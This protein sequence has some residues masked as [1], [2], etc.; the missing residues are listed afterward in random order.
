M[1]TLLA[2]QHL[3]TQFIHVQYISRRLEGN[4]TIKTFKIP[5]NIRSAHCV[6]LSGWLVCW[7]CLSYAWLMSHVPFP[8]EIWTCKHLLDL[9]R[10]SPP[11]KIYKF[12]IFRDCTQQ[13]W[14]E[15]LVNNLVRGSLYQVV[16]WRSIWKSKFGTLLPKILIHVHLS[17]TNKDETTPWVQLLT[18]QDFTNFCLSVQKTYWHTNKVFSDA[19][20]LNI[21]HLKYLCTFY[22]DSQ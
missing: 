3:C 10:R 13:A 9:Q 5:M 17:R 2:D 11:E 18:E 20:V 12:S 19:N 1:N 21:H 6:F 8:V 16:G 4:E 14:G 15:H 22:H 7:C